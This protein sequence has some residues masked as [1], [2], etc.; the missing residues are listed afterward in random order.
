MQK[1]LVE[2]P[3][4]S[5]A[6]RGE[7]RRTDIDQSYDLPVL[8]RPVHLPSQAQKKTNGI[9]TGTNT[10]TP[11]ASIQTKPQP[12]TLTYQQSH[13]T[14]MKSITATKTEK[15]DWAVNQKDII[16]T[17]KREG[18]CKFCH[19]KLSIYNMGEVCFAP[20][21]QLKRQKEEDYIY[22]NNTREQ[23]RYYKQQNKK[24]YER[25]KRENTS[26]DIQGR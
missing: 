21:C 16:P 18:H 13:T 1:K 25:K 10:T 23:M 22:D 8:V 6:R 26:A 24:Y 3:T 11:S 17:R 5:S 20:R 14:N 7:G 12:Q 19:K 15:R 9:R 4:A 2:L